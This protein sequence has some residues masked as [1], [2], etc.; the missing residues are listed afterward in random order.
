M[1]LTLIVPIISFAAV[2]GVVGVLA[3]VFRDAG[4]NSSNRLDVL[5][6]KK[7]KDDG[8]ADILKK[9]AFESDKRSLLELLVPK[10]PSLEKLFEQ[11]EANIKPG[12][13]FITAAILAAGGLT[14]SWLARVPWFLAPLAGLVMFTIPFL[15]LLWKRGSRLKKFA[16]QMPDAMELLARAL[17][18]GQSL[19][20]GLHTVSEEMPNP[21]AKE[22]GRVY[23]EQNLGIPLE[24]AMTGMC[25]RVPNLDLRFFVTSVAIQRQTGGDMAEILDKIGYVIRERYRI[26]GQVKALTGEGRLSGIVLLA[27]PFALFGFMLHIKP[28]YVEMLWTD[29]LGIK[30]SVG[31]LVLQLLGA[32]CIKKIVDIKV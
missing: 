20:A 31:A 6:G 10:I 5:I 16:A 8:S 23:E 26:L 27:L 12:A 28:D 11:A 15:W 25:E 24:E 19:G 17:R 2:A 4:P 1:S 29:P 7:R 9:S 18:A 3:F 32:I 22:F 30:M 21:I 14:V 13:L